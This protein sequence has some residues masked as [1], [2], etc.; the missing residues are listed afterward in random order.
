MKWRKAELGKARDRSLRP[1][2]IVE[3]RSAEEILASLDGDASID[4]MPFMP[5]MLRYSGQ[6]FTVSRRVEKICDT[7]SGGFPTSLRMRDTVLLDD[8]RCD[9]S[10]HGGCQAGCRFYWKEA[11]LRRVDAGLG[12]EGRSEDPLAELEALARDAAV[13]VFADDGSSV[14]SYR[15]QATEALRAT[16]PLSRY[17]PRQY[18]REL[19]SGN[20]GLARFVRVAVRG[21]RTAIGRR[22]RLLSWFPLPSRGEPAPTR[23]GLDLQPGDTVEVRSPDEIADS[24]DEGGKSRGLAFDWEMLPYCGGRYRVQDRVERIIDEG[25]GQ[26]IEISSD[27]L[28]LD[29]VVCS[30]EHS[31]GRW[32]CPR[33]IYPFWR[34]AWLRR[35]EDPDASSSAQ[36]DAEVHTP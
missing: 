34:E 12:R 24:V 1:G 27:C 22:L 4:A 5:E 16:E 25:T 17:D 29:G 9:G 19:T 6:R 11:W 26:M 2:D 23:G 14:E 32:F 15:C 28:I 13:A 7:V 35:V 3:V 21:L 30:G 8:L 10:A 36:R 20:F 33:A 31:N 18:I